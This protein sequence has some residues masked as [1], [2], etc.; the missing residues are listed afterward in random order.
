MKITNLAIQY[1][2]SIAVMVAMITFGGAGAYV[3]LPKEANPS[4]EIPTLVITTI[5]AGASPDDIEALITQPMEEEIQGLSGIKNLDSVSSEGA[6][7]VIVEFEPD[8]S[9]D[10][11]TQ[12]IREKVDLAKPDLPDDAEEPIIS[13]ID[14]S[15]FPVMT[16]NL[17]AHYPLSRLKDVAEELQDALE[18]IPSVLEVEIIGGL[19]EE[20][21]I[22]VDLDALQGYN[23]GFGD[24]SGAIAKENSNIPGGTV[25]VGN[26]SYLVRADGKFK[27]VKKM[28]DIVLNQGKGT[29]IFLRDV[30]TAKLGYKDRTSYARLEILRTE[31]DIGALHDE[32]SPGYRTVVSLAVKKRSGENILDTSDAVHKILDEF[33]FPKDTQVI[34]T[35]DQSENVEQM[36]KDLEN[37]I[38]SG[39]LFVVAVLLFFLGVRN[40]LLVGVAIPMSMLTSFLV[41]KAM[42]QTLNFVILFSLIIALGMLVDNAIVIVENIYRYM[43]MGHARWEAARLGTAEV[44]G[45]VV[46]STA[47]TVAAF[48]PMLGWPGIIG[49]FMSYLPLTLIVTL[50]SSLFVA[51]IINPVITGFFGQVEGVAQP[52]GP[53]WLRVFGLVMI[54]VCA[55]MVGLAAWR[56]FLVILLAGLFAYTM[57]MLLMR[58]IARR[59][60]GEFLPWLGD[61]YRQFLELMLARS[62]EGRADYFKNMSAL[63]AFLGGLVLLILGGFSALLLGRQPALILLVPGGIS[64]ALGLLGILLHTVETV[65]CGRYLSLWMGIGF[66]IL[67]GGLLGLLRLGGVPLPANEIAVLLLVPALVAALGLLGGLLLRPGT[68]LILSDNRAK[69]VN[70]VLGTL[71]VILGLY[72]I[73]PTGVA[74]FPDSDPRQVRISAEAALGTTIEASDNTAKLIA[75]RLNTVFEGEPEV[76]RSLKN[77]LVNVGLA[78]SDFG[79]TTGSPASSLVTLNLVDFKDRPQPSRV[80]MQQVR[81]GLGSV[82]GV[83]LTFDKDQQG[84]PTGP[85]VNIEVSG[86]SYA[87]VVELA[88]KVRGLLDSWA[89]SGTVPGLVDI[90]DN[91]DVGRPELKVEIDR[92]RAARFGLSTQEIAFMIRTAVSGAEASKFRKGE[93]EYDIVVRL[94]EE[95]RS[96]LE[97]VQNLTVFHEG[98]QIPLASVA[99]FELSSGL[100]SITRKDVRRVVTVTGEVSAGHNKQEVL[101][102]V[103]GRL[104]ASLGALPPG[105]ALSYTGESEDQQESFSFLTTALVTGAALILMILIAQFNSITSPALIMGAVALSMIGVLLGLLITRTPFSLFTFIG[106]ISLAG[107]VV[108]NNIVLIDYTEQLRDAGKKKREAI[109]EAGATRLRPVLLTALTTVLGL[110][111]LTFGINVDF[112][113]LLQRF[114]PQLQIGSENTQFWGPMGTA[115]ISGLSFATFLTLVIVPVLYSLMDS[116]LSR[117]QLAAPA[118]PR[119]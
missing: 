18:L 69:L 5:Y 107:I 61:F 114:D 76:E 87:R 97:S 58:H 59:F 43:E 72:T 14:L 105:Y 81:E 37:N 66:F 93:D 49:E 57:H 90:D 73:A 103:Q 25:D 102:N 48:V 84:P 106:V 27:D 92:E 34:I 68:R 23:L 52:R 99:R 60:A 6:S 64:L 104:Q 20:V 15:E 67:G 36:V 108:N 89:A 82:T 77:I 31:D 21:Q 9:M 38:V 74:F 85:P 40:S 88:K 3:T 96:S 19:D 62:Y 115:I 117:L 33:P 12:D 110:V 24:I 95:D 53:L 65:F 75:Q 44:G 42:G 35:G 41:F 100:G 1:R 98:Q 79:G 109:V 119:D 17:A 50:S 51:I 78:P 11:A 4:I 101:Q 28:E 2:T 22:D 32:P 63:V 116:V 118:E 55:V 46:A 94:R 54:G 83:K 80:T 47:T 111:P 70:T 10:K 39:L 71:L 112:I 45:A 29:P 7:T 113:S 26:K 86:P 30:A 91:L 16:V 8:V 13:E 56:A